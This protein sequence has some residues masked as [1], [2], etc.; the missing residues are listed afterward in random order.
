MVGFLQDGSGSETQQWSQNFPWVSWSQ[1]QFGLHGPSLE[2]RN[3]NHFQL[4][5][6]EDVEVIGIQMPQNIEGSRDMNM[7]GEAE[8]T[9]KKDDDTG[10]KKND[11][12]LALKTKKNTEKKK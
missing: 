2:S 3:F 8:D 10:K 7:R 1:P 4:F 6:D 9:T 12:I 11:K 5:N